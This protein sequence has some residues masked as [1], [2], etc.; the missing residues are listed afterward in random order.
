MAKETTWVSLR[1][2]PDLHTRVTK[3]A[4]RHE[5]STSEYIRQALTEMLMQRGEYTITG[6]TKGTR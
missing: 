2:S 4:A 3:A 6:P 5:V 1:L